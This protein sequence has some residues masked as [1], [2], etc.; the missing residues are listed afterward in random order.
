MYSVQILTKNIYTFSKKKIFQKKW[1][2]ERGKRTDAEHAVVIDIYYI[3]KKKRKKKKPKQNKEMSL[4]I[5]QIFTISFNVQK[6]IQLMCLHQNDIFLIDLFPSSP[7]PLFLQS[8]C[9]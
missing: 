2:S 5:C 1:K 9:I 4:H 3:A 7:P 8:L 6:C